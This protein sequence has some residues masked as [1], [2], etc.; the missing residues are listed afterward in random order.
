M[1]RV[2]LGLQARVRVVINQFIVKCT[3]TTHSS[4]SKLFVVCATIQLGVSSV[5]V[6]PHMM[7][8]LTLD[9]TSIGIGE[10]L[11]APIVAVVI[12]TLFRNRPMNL[13]YLFDLYRIWIFTPADTRDAWYWPAMISSVRGPDVNPMSLGRVVSLY[14]RPVR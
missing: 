11:G 14:V 5:L 12:M 1:S 13:L 9:G 6:T 10:R 4:G 3:T 7:S 2:R 8:W